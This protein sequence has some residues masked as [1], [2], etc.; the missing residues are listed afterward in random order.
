MYLLARAS[1]F[2]LPMTESIIVKQSVSPH[3]YIL[4]NKKL[5]RLPEGWSVL[6]PGNA[7]ITRTL[8]SLGESWTIQ[9]KKGRKIF[10]KGVAAPI[11]NIEK[12]KKMVEKKR[13]TPSYQR[14]LANSRK[15]REQKEKLYCHEFYSAVLE[16]LNF[17]PRYQEIGEKMAKFITD[18]ATPVGSGTVARTKMIEI[19]ERA[20]R[21]VIAWM[22]HQTT[23]YDHMT[24]ARVKG[25]RREVRQQLAAISRQLLQLYRSGAEVSTTCPLQ[26]ALKKSE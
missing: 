9:E 22:R 21:A 19:E 4:P 16:F 17:A 7:A 15:L 3:L 2:F 10:S 20:E 1:T 18:H 12:A 5:S 26:A 8:K 13:S 14:Q 11:G 25:K 24:I 23:A 6:P